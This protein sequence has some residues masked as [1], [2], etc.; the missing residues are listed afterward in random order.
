MGIPNGVDNEKK[1]NKRAHIEKSETQNNDDD[2]HDEV[3]E[4]IK[5]DLWPNPLTYFNNEADEEDFEKKEGEMTKQR[6]LVHC[7]LLISDI[8]QFRQP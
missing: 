7:N 3:V 2:I 5:E 4:I 1:R 8:S 6:G